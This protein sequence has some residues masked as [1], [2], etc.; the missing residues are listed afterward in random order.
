MYLDFYKLR[1]KPFSAV[2]DTAFLF[3]SREHSSA[4]EH[5]LY[6]INSKDGFMLITGDVGTGKTTLC[7]ALLNEL[8]EKSETALIFNPPSTPVEL[9]QSILQDLGIPYSAETKKELI[10]KLNQYLLRYAEKERGVVV[11]ID[12]AQDLSEDVLEEL[13]LLSN[14][15][16]EKEKLIQII[17]SGQPEL[18]E[19][20]SKHSLRQL[21]QRISI[22][23][24]LNPLSREEVESYIQYRLLKAGSSGDISFSKPALKNIF[25]CTQGVPRLINLV[26]DK[27][28]LAGYVAQKKEISESMVREAEKTICCAQ[29]SSLPGLKLSY[30][31]LSIIIIGLIAAGFLTG[32]WSRLINNDKKAIAPAFASVKNSGTIFK[33][34]KPAEKET[35]RPA[36]K[37]EI[38]VLLSSEAHEDQMPPAVKEIKNVSPPSAK[39]VPDAIFDSNGVMRSKSSFVYAREALGTILKLWGISEEILLNKVSKWNIDSTFSFHDH[40]KSFNLYVTAAMSDIVQIAKINYPCIIP[41]EVEDRYRFTVLS[42][43]NNDH[44][45]LLDPAEGKRV[46]SKQ[47]LQ[48]VW[49]GKVFYLWKD[50]DRLPAA[51]RKGD[52]YDEIASVKKRLNSFG[53]DVAPPHST[54][55]D[56]KLDMAVK[57]FQSEWGIVP[58][59]IFGLKTK[60]VFYRT[61]YPS[62]VPKLQSQTHNSQP[63]TRNP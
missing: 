53:F 41:I 34:K 36:E 9:L 51:F 27:A 16:T 13:R 14:L 26:C 1:E 46:L 30:T 32:D 31:I 60:L 3:K 48:R 33:K 17:L 52:T 2:P 21:F 20:L 4:L 45:T 11:I 62:K 24:N 58:D 25:H 18:L 8:N 6:G 39:D 54:F 57:K 7:R 42:V 35:R 28:L 43:V 10:D 5:L 59:G 61:I 38:K 37:P 19:K 22:H 40:A 29:T 63:V 55:F 50:F 15:E 49:S 47:E 56:K 23:Y 44:F 12:E